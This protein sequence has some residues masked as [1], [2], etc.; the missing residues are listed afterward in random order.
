MFYVFQICVCFLLLR[1]AMFYTPSLCCWVYHHAEICVI[2]SSR[3]IIL[4]QQT[5][6]TIHCSKRWRLVYSNNMKKEHFAC[7]CWNLIRKSRI[8]LLLSLI[9]T[10]LFQFHLH[11]R[12]P[13]FPVLLFNSIIGFSFAAALSISTLCRGADWPVGSWRCSAPAHHP[14]LTCTTV[15]SLSFSTSPSY[16]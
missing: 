3:P 11:I 9:Y 6:D 8:T 4:Q 13:S 7:M 5:V 10:F 16:S 15:W 2:D 14:P 12:S 1:L